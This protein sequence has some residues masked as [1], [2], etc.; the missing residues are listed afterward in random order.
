MATTTRLPIRKRCQNDAKLYTYEYFAPGDI[1]LNQMAAGYPLARLGFASETTEVVAP[2]SNLV[3]NISRG[4]QDY[5]ASHVLEVHDDHR[6]WA[7]FKR[8]THV[9]VSNV[10]I[11]P[12]SISHLTSGANLACLRSVR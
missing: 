9:H 2:K 6:A 3:P 1:C 11:H 12:L 8:V 10:L 5:L 7:V 4:S